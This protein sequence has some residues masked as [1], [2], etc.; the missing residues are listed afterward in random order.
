MIEILLVDDELLVRTGIKMLLDWE[1][2]GCRI[3]GEAGNG[4]EAL[5]MTER[6]QP[7]L[8]LTDIKMPGMNGLELMKELKT[9]DFHGMI[10]VLSNHNDFQYAQEAI[11]SGA[12]DYILKTDLNRE[13]FL[14][15]I[16]TLKN[17][18]PIE[19]Q[20]LRSVRDPLHSS[21]ILKEILLN[22]S[23]EI[24]H[25]SLE[26]LEQSWMKMF[27]R[28]GI[29]Q[30]RK[31]TADNEE[32]MTIFQITEGIISGGRA[33]FYDPGPEKNY[34]I[35]LLYGHKDDLKDDKIR[36]MEKRLRNAL[37]TYLSLTVYLGMGPLVSDL[38]KLNKGYIE[39]E[40][41]M[42][43]SFFH[44]GMPLGFTDD[45]TEGTESGR[46]TPDL[47][48]EFRRL[49]SQTVRLEEKESIMKEIFG[50]LR[51]A[52]NAGILKNFALQFIA[53]L[54]RQQAGLAMEGSGESPRQIPLSRLWQLDSLEALENLFQD[55]LKGMAEQNKNQPVDLISRCLAYIGENLSRPLSLVETAEQSG[56]SGSYFSSWFKEKTGENFSDYLIRKRIKLARELLDTHP[57]LR[58]YEIAAQ[59]GIS[60]E[61]YFS[62]LFKAQTGRSPSEYRKEMHEK[63]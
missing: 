26:N 40:E 61:K 8:I 28:P 54:N 38:N 34:W 17:R 12:A 24:R 36:S 3:C 15:F 14:S 9:R 63:G 49:I 48:E 45:P 6:L 52:E 10:A 50:Q 46:Q 55:A 58:I 44:P 39:A 30:I 35:I 60:N 29:L 1:S 13:N 53:Y 51:L 57:E 59:C 31:T 19:A 20:T 7:D 37:S 4:L 47:S 2:E 56:L 32:K 16:R 42:W 18:I 5:E 21:N 62:R 33:F 22:S 11:R 23:P 41:V 27:F 25:K 43:K